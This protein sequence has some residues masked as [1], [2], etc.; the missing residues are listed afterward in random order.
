MKKHLAATC[1]IPT[2]LAAIICIC[3]CGNQATLSTPAT[4]STTPVIPYTT[5]IIST[6]TKTQPANSTTAIIPVSTTAVTPAVPGKLTTVDFMISGL[7][8]PESLNFVVIPRDENSLVLNLAAAI[9]VKL[10]ADNGGTPGEL[11]QQWNNVKLDQALY[12]DKLGTLA[13]MQYDNFRPASGL[14]GF[15]QVTVTFEGVSLSSPVQRAMI[16]FPLAC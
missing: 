7:L 9:S 6:D 13:S 4:T 5:P 15:I 12:I 3:G 10:W 2:C 11:L 8:V 16:R 14:V 1:A